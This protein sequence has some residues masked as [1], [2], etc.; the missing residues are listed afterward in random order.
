MSCGENTKECI[1]K[2]RLYSEILNSHFLQEISTVE[3]KSNSMK[4]LRK[5]QSTI[6]A[7]HLGGKYAD[8]A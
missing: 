7:L 1:T 6:P 2:L 4:Y 5:E 8:N 3:T